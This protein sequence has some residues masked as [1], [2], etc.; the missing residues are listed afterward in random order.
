MITL[1]GSKKTYT[2]RARNVY[3][4]LVELDTPLTFRESGYYAVV[5]FSFLYVCLN[6]FI[7]ATKFDPVKLVL[8]RLIPCKKAEQAAATTAEVRG[9]TSNRM[10]EL[11]A[12]QLYAT[13]PEQPGAK[14][15]TEL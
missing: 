9:S 7:Y 13:Q 8:L 3:Y 12:A 4:L 5:F 1:Q 11:R 2:F 14:V 10:V 6:P 15:N